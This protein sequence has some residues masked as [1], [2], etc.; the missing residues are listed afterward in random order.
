MRGRAMR[1]GLITILGASV[2][3]APRAA[4]GQTVVRQDQPLAFASILPG[5][6]QTVTVTN[7]TSRGVVTLSGSGKLSVTFGLPTLLSPMA[8]PG[9]PGLPI[10][11]GAGDGQV[12]TRN[13][14]YTFDPRVGTDVNLSG[15]HDTATLYFGGRV[16]ADPA[17]PAGS[18]TGSII[19]TVVP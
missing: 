16:Q 10:A 19:I 5:T 14:S 4:A 18:Y 17:Q 12:A 6:G 13:K 15:S 11:F 9:G 8:G 3:L 1:T 2:L 7:V